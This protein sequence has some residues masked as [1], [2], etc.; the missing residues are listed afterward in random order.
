MQVGSDGVRTCQACEV[1]YECD[2]HS[3]TRCPTGYYRSAA[4][5]ECTLCPAGSACPDATAAVAC[6][7]G[8]FSGPGATECTSCPAGSA[9]AVK[10]RSSASTRIAEPCAAGETS[11]A[12]SG[13]CTA[14]DPG[15]YA[16][17]PDA[18]PQPCPAGFHAD[19]Q[20]SACVPAKSTEMVPAGGASK[21]TACR[22]DGTEHGSVGGT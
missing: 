20:T 10:A 7:A 16:L 18:T 9:C 5:R 15:E 13:T 8:T 1:G 22:N 17:E 3:Q 2:G 19:G 11:T 6:A 14:G 4:E 21:A 12:G